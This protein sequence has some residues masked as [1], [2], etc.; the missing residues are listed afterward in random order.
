M[1]V[2]ACACTPTKAKEGG[3]QCYSPL[4]VKDPQVDE[5]QARHEA[6]LSELNLE[7]SLRQQLQ[8][9]VILVS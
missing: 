7:K 2:A 6:V 3:E 8:D 5:L 1:K 4:Q 9:E